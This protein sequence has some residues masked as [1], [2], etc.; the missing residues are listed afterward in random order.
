M[1]IALKDG[2]IGIAPGQF[3]VLYNN[4]TVIGGGVISI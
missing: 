2:D 1:N 3:G 4:D